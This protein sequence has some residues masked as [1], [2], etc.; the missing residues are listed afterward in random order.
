MLHLT[1]VEKHT[2]RNTS[3][4]GFPFD[5]PALASFSALDFQSPLTFLVGENG[6]GKST[7]L[8]ALACA[9]RSITVGAE[10]VETDP[11]LAEVRRFAHALRLTW[12]KRTRRGFFMRAEDFFGY[13]KRMSQLRQELSQDAASIDQEYKGRSELAKAL[14]RMPYARELAALQQ[15]YGD[16]LDTSSHGESFFKLFRA[17]FTGP[18]LYLLDEP[19]APLSPMRQLTLITLLKGMI[20]QGA[21]FVIATHSPILMAYPDATILSFDDGTIQPVAYADLEH[22]TIMRDF[23]TNPDAYL[24]YL[25]A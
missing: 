16:G 5:V 10:S 20:D 9:A 15:S 1:R 17:R 13:A 24:R 14:A 12:T 4:T 8:E 22:V 18:G 11:T 6:S 25:L 3:E 7:F 19:E 2:Q 23:L 21:Q